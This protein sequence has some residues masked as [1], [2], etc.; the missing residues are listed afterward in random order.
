MEKKKIT[1]NNILNQLKKIG[2]DRK[3]IF[4]LSDGQARL[5]VNNCTTMLNE[6]KANFSLGPLESYILGQ[7]Y[8]A[9]SLISSNIKE[10]DRIQLNIECGGPI[11]GISVEA[12]ANGAIRG[13]LNNN[14]I[15]WDKEEPPTMD[16]LYGPGFLTITKLLEG[17]KTPFSGQVM[18]EYSSLAKNLAVYYQ[19]SEQTPTVFAIDI[20]TNKNGQIFGAGGFFVQLM[21]ECSEEFIAKLE[22][23]VKGLPPIGESISEGIDIRDYIEENFASLKPKYLDTKPV[24]FYCPCLRDNFKGFLKGLPEEEKKAIFEDNK[25]PLKVK[26]FN[27]GTD[28]SFE[29][30][31]VKEIFR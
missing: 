18:M 8:I 31:E 20:K 25:F 5:V 10:K 2:K 24:M 29:K 7:S 30:S 23:L 15:P 17:Y 6:V 27:C 28:Y 13:Y 3:E 1:D 12:W 22:T 14:P 9:G 11:K 16:E 19:K 26:C 21:P 4:T